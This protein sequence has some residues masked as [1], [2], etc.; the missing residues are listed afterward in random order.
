MLR[1]ILPEDVLHSW[2]RVEAI[3]PMLLL[4]LVGWGYFFHTSPLWLVLGTP[5]H[6]F[7][8]IF[9]LGLLG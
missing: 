3:G 8:S 5:V 9:T 6:F 2:S 7:S 4:V 1:G